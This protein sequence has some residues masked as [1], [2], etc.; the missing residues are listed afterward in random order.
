MKKR[1]SGLSL[2]SILTICL[3][4][5]VIAGCVFMF[6][7]IRGGAD[8]GMDA[9][10]MIGAVHSFMQSAGSAAQ[11]QVT[12]RTVTVTLAPVTPPPATPVPVTPAPVN[13]PYEPFSFTLTA[14]GLLS[15]QSEIS[16][17]VYSKADKALNYTPVVEPIRS[18]IYSDVN[19]VTL[20]QTINTVDR[21]YSDT[22]APAEAAIAIQS[23]GI[24][25]VALATE[26]IL[27]QGRQGAENTV[28]MLESRQLGTAGVNA[29]GASRTRLV[30]VNG[31][32]VAILSYT[33]ALTSKSRNELAKDN[34]FFAVY[35]EN[36]ARA[37]I[38]NARNQGARCVIVCMYWGRQDAAS[39][40]T[41]QKNAA[42][43][44]AEMGA[45]V[46]LGTRPSRV[47]PMELIY[48]TGPDGKSH[49]A[50]VAY[51]L[52]TL[53]TE[54]REAYDICGLLLHLRVR[55]DEQG[56][57]HFEGI[58]YTPTYIWRQSVSGQMQY[59]LLCSA[60]PPPEGMSSQ[61]KQVMQRSLARIQAALKNSPVNL[62]Q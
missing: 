6:G 45:D 25:E 18:K 17:S 34:S 24:G 28:S 48:C 12:V 14:G 62:R 5:A 27:D 33:D 10:R 39:V 46:I 9:R 15:F 38:Q 57:V 1:K 40:T 44:L 59:R 58:E 60:D 56:A 20:P 42:Q 3:T 29:M 11:P 52:G 16:D 32:A 8:A 50:F 36:M 4:I 41:A 35:D 54:S 22:L 2:G 49:T 55:S 13:N 23:M 51:S 31:G 7:R 30:R 43:A 26:H 47:L 53:L 19:L 21:K 37:D 61:Q